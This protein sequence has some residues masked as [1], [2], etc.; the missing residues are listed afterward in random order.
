MRALLSALVLISLIAFQACKDSGIVTPV[1]Q[2]NI[3]LVSVYSTNASTNGVYVLPINLRDYALIADGTNGLQIV[4]ITIINHPDS[5]SSYDTDGN[6]NDVTAAYINGDLYAFISDYANGFVVVDIDDPSNPFLIGT[7]LVTGFVNTSFIDQNNK[8][9][10]IAMES[11]QIQVYDISQLP[12]EP[13]F[14]A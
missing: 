3:N 8:L 1:D 11:G 10:Y 9:A 4:D 7:I 2:S 13:T 5:V 6:A 14:V 12:D